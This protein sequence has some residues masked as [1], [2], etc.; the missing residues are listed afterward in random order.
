MRMDKRQAEALLVEVVA[1]CVLCCLKIASD[2]LLI[3]ARR[4]PCPE[5]PEAMCSITR[6]RVLL[7]GRYPLEP[8][9]TRI[10]G[11]RAMPENEVSA[12]ESAAEQFQAAAHVDLD[13]TPLRKG[14]MPGKAEEAPVKED[15]DGKGRGEP[16]EARSVGEAKGRH[17]PEKMLP[18]YEC[19]KRVWALKIK[20][21][22][23]DNADQGYKGT[24]GQLQFCEPGHVPR[25]MSAAWMAKHQPKAGGYWVL[26]ENAYE[27]F[28]PGEAFENGYAR[29]APQVGDE[30][31]VGGTGHDP[32]RAPVGTYPAQGGKY[33]IR[34][35]KPTGER[36]PHTAASGMS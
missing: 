8:I 30:S 14:P 18:R 27:S 31:G 9:G 2:T 34:N 25:M 20:D 3:M 17:G 35:G 6:A 10:P 16:A 7:E 15:A 29:M 32:T 4:D 33:V 26:H 12:T 22:W 24:R 11:E 13:S 1:D 36:V 23:V 5:I 21:V 19:H 28:S